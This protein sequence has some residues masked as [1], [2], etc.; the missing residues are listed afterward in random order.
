MGLPKARF[1]TLVWILVKTGKTAPH[2]E[3]EPPQNQVLERKAQ[4]ADRI[5]PTRTSSPISHKNMKSTALRHP[6]TSEYR[7]NAGN[8][9]IPVRRV[10]YERLGAK[11][12]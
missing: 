7:N 1:W 4:R 5:R 12:F 9:L 10:A 11:Y 3:D 8:R 2:A 6:Y